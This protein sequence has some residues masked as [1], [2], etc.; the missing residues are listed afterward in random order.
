VN[1]VIKKQLPS[2]SKSSGI[3]LHPA[4]APH[5]ADIQTRRSVDLT[6][7]ANV[8]QLHL[9]VSAAHNLTITADVPTAQHGDAVGH[10]VYCS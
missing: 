9:G 6:I 5:A 4:I 1:E 10:L 3:A 8:L 7:A 2:K